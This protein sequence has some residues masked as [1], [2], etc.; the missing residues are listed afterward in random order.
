MHAVKEDTKKM[1]IKQM[2]NFAQISSTSSFDLAQRSTSESINFQ[3]ETQNTEMII[4]CALIL[5]CAISCLVWICC[6]YG[7][8][9]GNNDKDP[10]YVQ[11]L[12]GGA[13]YY[14]W[15]DSQEVILTKE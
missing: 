11:C 3:W 10:E 7:V 13:L 6:Y 4:F 1:I 9:M 15:E 8:N 14:D 12:E 5:L 2:N